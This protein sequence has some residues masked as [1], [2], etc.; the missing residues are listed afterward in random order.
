M[1]GQISIFEYMYEK[2]QQA[3][4][5]PIGIKGLCDD[6]YCP[7]CGY[8]FWDYGEKSEVDCDRCPECG[9]LVDWRPWHR[10]NDGIKT[11]VHL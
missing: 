7:E 5:K 6:P 4:K 2:E 10:V 8:Y 9:C 1:K 3:K 11:E